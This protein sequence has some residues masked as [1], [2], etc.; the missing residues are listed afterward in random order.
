MKEENDYWRSKDPS[1]G[2]SVGN[3]L[4]LEQTLGVKLL[5]SSSFNSEINCILFLPGLRYPWK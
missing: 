2:S 1:L 5:Q 3:D 4:V